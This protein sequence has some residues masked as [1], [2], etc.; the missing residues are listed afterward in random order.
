MKQ[1]ELEALLGRPLTP[2]E[3]T[4]LKLYLDIAQGRLEQLVCFPMCCDANSKFFAG[5][6]GYSTVFTGA[7]TKISEVKV[8]GSVTTDFIPYLWDSRNGSW[9]NSIVFDKKLCDS[10]E[11]EVKADWGFDK[12]PSD[13]KQL[14][15]KLFELAGKGS[16]ADS[17]VQ[18]KQTEDFRITFNLNQ[19]A[20]DK[21]VSDNAQTIAK[22]SI[23]NIGNIKSGE[24]E[25]GRYDFRY[26]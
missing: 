20:E 5:R 17:N 24:V 18:S 16:K 6:E 1:P 13:L 19:S 4:N 15:A 12:M 23:C 2:N 9:F 3:V 11:V 25:Y 21:I 7:F 8:N 22:Y 14:L 10:D 26:V